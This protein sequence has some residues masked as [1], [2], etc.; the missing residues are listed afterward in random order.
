[1]ETEE[2]TNTNGDDN[3]EIKLLYTGIIGAVVGAA[4]MGE[5]RHPR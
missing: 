2:S 1:M 5:A 4:L 3:Y